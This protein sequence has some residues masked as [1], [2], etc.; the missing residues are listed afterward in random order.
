[1]V[2]RAQQRDHGGGPQSEMNLLFGRVSSKCRRRRRDDRIGHHDGGR[3]AG[4]QEDIVDH[5][6]AW[7]LVVHA[8]KHSGQPRSAK[9]PEPNSIR[10]E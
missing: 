5:G 10:K 6:K 9:D 8:R 3:Q 4:V 1:M 7:R 2:K